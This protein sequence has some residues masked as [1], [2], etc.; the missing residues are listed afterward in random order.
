MQRDAREARASATSVAKNP[1]FEQKNSE[2]EWEFDLMHGID[3]GSG[4]RL[5]RDDPEP[6]YK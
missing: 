1:K 6:G 2:T 3:V 4:V 5:S